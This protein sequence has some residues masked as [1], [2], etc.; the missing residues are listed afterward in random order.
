MFYMQDAQCTTWQLVLNLWK[1]I[2]FL[3]TSGLGAHASGAFIVSFFQETLL[4]HD[5]N[6]NTNDCF[7]V[8]SVLAGNHPGRVHGRA[9]LVGAGHLSL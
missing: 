3:H 9:G 5:F 4:F 7:Q 1:T 8:R 6:T 2:F